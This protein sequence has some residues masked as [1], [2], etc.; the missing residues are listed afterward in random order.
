MELAD[1]VVE[2]NYDARKDGRAPVNSN[3]DAQSRSWARWRTNASASARQSREQHQLKPQTLVPADLARP[4]LHSD[5]H[6]KATD[7]RN[8]CRSCKTVRMP[9]RS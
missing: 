6:S 1:F 2:T 8:G 5:Q 9:F 3:E 4:H 7:N